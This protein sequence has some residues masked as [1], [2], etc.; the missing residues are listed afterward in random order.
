MGYIRKVMFSNDL[1]ANS[2]MNEKDFTRSRKV[3]F[4]T[5]I[6]MILNMIKKS[7]QLEIDEFL[8]RF[9][10]EG[11]NSETYTKQSFSEARQKLSPKAFV[12]LN[13]AF[14]EK[15][16]EDGDFKRF[17][18]YRLLA[19]DGSS[20][21]VPNNS[22]T[23]KFF[24]YAKNQTE[25]FKLSRALSS[26]LF[27][28]E[29]RII[30]G[31]ILGKCDASE[32]D[33]AIKNI[34]KMQKMSEGKIK[35]LIL[36]D[37]GYPSIAFISYLMANNIKF[38]M[39]APLSFLRAVNYTQACDENVEIEV[40]KKRA[41]ELKRQGTPIP[42]GT[43]IKFRMLKIKLN[44]GETEMLITN[45]DYAELK[46]EESKDLYYKRWGIETKF[47]ELKNKFE[48]ENFSGEKP[49]L[50]EQDFYATILLSNI[51]SIFEQEAEKG[52][53][54]HN[55]KKDLKYEYKI[56]KNILV[57]KLKNTLIEMLLEDNN[58]KKSIMY[59]W[60]IEEI[61]RNVVPIIKDRTFERN[62]TIRSNKYSENRKRAL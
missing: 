21:E 19:I 61:K 43:I 39:R 5:L 48:I 28:I 59:N 53:E 58:E 6:C 15:F 7:T 8:K 54:E 14:I 38:L 27:D 50:I 41:K 20:I 4:L 12:I 49:L 40:T 31:S 26:S 42:Y 29:N 17:N 9:N 45:L 23:Q 36:F 24:G 11:A 3:G 60:F 13:D 35:N 47:D 62:K 56:N 51:A 18:E 10:P 30:V 33:L 52:L 55:A 34:E 46:Y 37:R 57:G 25:E 1:K 2:K 16:Y 44:T 32:R 22:A